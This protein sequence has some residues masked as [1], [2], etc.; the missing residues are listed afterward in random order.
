M[1]QIPNT[2]TQNEN[3]YIKIKKNVKTLLKHNSQLLGLMIKNN[4]HSETLIYI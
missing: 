4:N 3:S 1:I 2:K